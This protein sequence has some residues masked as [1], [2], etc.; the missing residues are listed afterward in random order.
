MVIKKW[1]FVKINH[2]YVKI[3]D[4]FSVLAYAEIRLM[5]FGQKKK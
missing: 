5:K 1:M 3:D 2:I 4:G